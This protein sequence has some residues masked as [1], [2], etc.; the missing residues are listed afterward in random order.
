MPIAV[1]HAL[2]KPFAGSKYATA[3]GLHVTFDCSSEICICGGRCE[4]STER[5]LEY[6][7]TI[8]PKSKPTAVKK[9]GE[10]SLHTD[11]LWVPQPKD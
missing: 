1:L 5:M 7:A 2:T 6:A 8:E 11:P 3:P 10:H 4:N 9:L